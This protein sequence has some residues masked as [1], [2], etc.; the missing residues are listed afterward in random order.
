MFGRV[1]QGHREEVTDRETA[2]GEDPGDLGGALVQL[3]EGDQS[4]GAVLG[5]E[6]DGDRVRFCLGR[7]PDLGA[8]GHPT[9]RH[10]RGHLILPCDRRST[11]D[12]DPS[13]S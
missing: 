7:V 3:A 6:H 9:V 10:D 11:L 5:R 12:I 1:A 2:V 8:V 4:L 13:P